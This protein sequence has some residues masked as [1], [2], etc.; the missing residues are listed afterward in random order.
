M[1]NVGVFHGMMLLLSPWVRNALKQLWRQLNKGKKLDMPP[2]VK[3]HLLCV[4]LLFLQGCPSGSFMSCDLKSFLVHHL[5]VRFAL[6][7]QCSEVF[8]HLIDPL[9]S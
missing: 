9:F 1:E 3:K 8:V 2:R 4:L 5:F 7:G 6:Q